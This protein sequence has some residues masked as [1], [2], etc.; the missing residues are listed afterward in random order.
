MK[1]IKYSMPFLILIFIG[2]G[3]SKKLSTEPDIDI[4]NTIWTLYSFEIDDDVVTPP[5]DQTYTLLF[6]PDSTLSGL[7]DCN[8]MGGSYK[9][10]ENNSLS[11][12]DLYATEMYC[13][14]ESMGDIYLA[15]LMAADSFGANNNKL[16]IYYNDHSK[17][18][19]LRD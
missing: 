14:D 16:T 12:F 4:L 8:V 15:A 7:S 11:L 18:I 3:C 1:I 6:K 19:F 10:G 2:I 5:E 9:L 13:G 17:L